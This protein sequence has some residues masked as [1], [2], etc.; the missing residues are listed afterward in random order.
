MGRRQGEELYVF[1]WIFKNEWAHIIKRREKWNIILCYWIWNYVCDMLGSFF[2]PRYPGMDCFGVRA[3]GG[4]CWKQMD[5]VMNGWKED[6]FFLIALRR[7][8]WYDKHARHVTPS[9]M[10]NGWWEW[11]RRRTSS[12]EN[13]NIVKINIQLEKSCASSISR[14]PALLNPPN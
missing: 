7:Q 5:W 11:R 14:P 6:M 1:E 12:K 4:G 2:T 13:T 10:W 8:I 9:D 3:S